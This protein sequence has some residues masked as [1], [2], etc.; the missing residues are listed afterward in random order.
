MLKLSKK[1][2]RIATFRV[3]KKVAERHFFEF[4]GFSSVLTHMSSEPD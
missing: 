3:S 1:K 2:W 4:Y